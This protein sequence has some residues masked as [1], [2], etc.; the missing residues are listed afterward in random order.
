M[1]NFYLLTIVMNEFESI[2]SYLHFYSN[3]K[4]L[5]LKYTIRKAN[6]P[7]DRKTDDK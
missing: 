5:K 4:L 1:L 7:P 6:L 2:E 3:L